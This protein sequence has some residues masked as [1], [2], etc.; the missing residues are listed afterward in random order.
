M[1]R[2][3]ITIGHPSALEPIV[4]FMAMDI[5]EGTEGKEAKKFRKEVAENTAHFGF[6]REFGGFVPAELYWAVSETISMTEKP[7]L[8]S[9][10][11]YW[12]KYKDFTQDNVQQRTDN[13]AG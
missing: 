6:P 1:R 7:V 9:D 5:K 4:P 13:P 2:I 10:N 12:R 11:W 3:F 8:A